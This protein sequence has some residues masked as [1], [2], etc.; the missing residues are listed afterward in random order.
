MSCRVNAS[1]PES[2]AF[3]AVFVLSAASSNSFEPEA[4]V[5][6]NAVSSATAILLMRSKS[7]TSS[8][9]EGPISSRTTAISS[10][11]MGFSTPSNLVERM[12]R[13]SRR[14]ST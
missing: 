5:R 9:Y 14:R 4:R 13:R 7:V 11:I 8:G 3:P 1:L 2:V 6:L 10:P 12:I